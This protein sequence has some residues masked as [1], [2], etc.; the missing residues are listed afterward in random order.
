MKRLLALL[1]GLCLLT[2]CATQGEYVPTGGGFSDED[3]AP[4]VNQNETEQE[5]RLAYNQ[6]A[7]FQPY[8]TTDTLNRSLLSLMYQGLFAVNSEYEATPILCKNYKVSP[9]MRTYTFYLERA[10]FADGQALTAQDVVASLKAAH[11]AGYYAGRLS[12]VKSIDI[13]E[14]GGVVLKLDTP[15]SNLPVLL[16]IPIVKA[17][18]VEAP[19]PYGTGAY[20]LVDTG[21]GKLLRR[22]PAW[23]CNAALPISAQEITLCHGTEQKELWD[24]YKFSGLSMVYTD[25][26]VDFRGDYEL[27]ESETG[28]FLYLSCNLHSGVFANKEIRR[29]LT[30]AMDRELLVQEYF[31]GFARSA[32]LPASAAFPHYSG[33]LAEKYAYDAAIF[34]QAVADAQLEDNSVKLLV[35]G[36]DLLRRR[37]ALAIKTMLEAGG[38]AVTINELSDEDYTNALL[39][40]EYDLYLGQTKLSPNMDLSAFFGEEGALNFGGLSDVAFYA[41]NQ[42]A[43]ADT[44]NYQS[45]HKMV[46]DDGRLC[47]LLFRSYAV[48]GRRGVFTNLEPARDNLFYYSLGKTMEEA[49]LMEE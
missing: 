9:D 31:Q 10:T 15:C 18:Q 29:A 45:L 43:L 47:P 12:H 44:G 30:H 14:D 38:L 32:T 26:Y 40:E 19:A 16:D 21:S 4:T 41:M 17:E 49:R 42:N 5:I 1:L 25:A 27:W 24:L 20:V 36:K 35:N 8:T 37:V 22:Q 7:G 11:K 2:G 23:W 39:W 33:T 6:E 34:A 48:Y 28:Q 3:N 13:A 46:M